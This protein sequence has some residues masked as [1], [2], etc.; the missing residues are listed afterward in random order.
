M[1]GLMDRQFAFASWK[2]HAGRLDKGG[3]GPIDDLGASPS[4]FQ[5]SQLFSWSVQ[6]ICSRM[7]R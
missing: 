1:G 3:Q 2:I 6:M 5:T 7:S 4:G